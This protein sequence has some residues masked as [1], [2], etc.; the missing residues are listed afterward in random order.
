[1]RLNLVLLLLL[2]LSVSLAFIPISHVSYG[3]N[4]LSPLVLQG[5][6]VCQRFDPNQ[7]DAC[8]DISAASGQTISTILDLPMGLGH[9]RWI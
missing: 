8:G 5:S 1:M 4:T 7:T 9:K 2:S 3:A 6:G